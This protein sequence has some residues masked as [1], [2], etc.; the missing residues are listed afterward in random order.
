[1]R[2]RSLVGLAIL[3][4]GCFVLPTTSA[5][6]A[7]ADSGLLAI[8]EERVIMCAAILLPDTQISTKP[9]VMRQ[10]RF[11]AQSASPATV[12]DRTIIVAFDSA[13]HVVFLQDV[14][15]QPPHGGVSATTTTLPDGSASG[16][17][18]TITMDSA[19]LAAAMTQGNVDA[20]KAAI[21]P[22]VQRPLSEI[23]IGKARTLATWL[24]V[25][26]C[27]RAR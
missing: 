24:W 22:G 27:D 14:L 19:A 15:S 13:G 11:A 18:L 8:P 26:R 1:M 10:F 17:H 6:Q 5:A 7:S 4:T 25:R 16:F 2:I 3:A 23:E 9:L 20:L 21:R 12:S